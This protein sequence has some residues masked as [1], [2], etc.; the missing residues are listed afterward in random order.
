[1]SGKRASIDLWSPGPWADYSELS[2]ALQRAG[3]VGHP[4]S[5]V[6]DLLPREPLLAEWMQ[7]GSGD[8]FDAATLAAIA[9]HRSIGRVQIQVAGADLAARLRDVADVIARA[10]GLGVR[11]ARCGLAHPW[12]RWRQFLGEGEPAGLQKALVVQVSNAQRGRIDSFGMNQFGLPDASYDGD[13]ILDPDATWMVFAFGVY[14]RTETPK[15]N[16]GDLFEIAEDMPPLRLMHEADDRFAVDDPF[17]NP[18]GIWC[19]TPE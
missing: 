8:A 1:M 6:F 7:H 13:D 18:H 14:L 16:D 2:D 3:D 17:F 11:L 15:L 4:P 5:P 12:S 10:G 19:L 9:E